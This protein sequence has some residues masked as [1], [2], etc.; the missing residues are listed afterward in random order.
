MKRSDDRILVT[1][2]G[3]LSSDNEEFERIEFRKSRGEEIADEIYIPMLET[4]IKEV[5]QRQVETG[6][7]VIS[8]GELGRRRTYAYY[9]H[10]MDGIVYR[11]CK[12]GEFGATIFN[13]RERR[14]FSKY[15]QKADED[16][17]KDGAPS[18]RDMR[19]VAVDELRAKDT[20]MLEEELDRFRRI[21]TELDLNDRDAFFPVISPG[22]LD[23]FIF[24]E[25]YKSEEEFIFALAE[26][27]RPE[28]EKIVEKGFIVQ[29]DAPDLPDAWA[30][31]VPEITLEDYRKRSMLRVEA[32]NHSLR[33]IPEE[34]VRYHLCWGSWNGP[35]MDDIPFRDVVDLMLKVKAQGY[36]L[37][38]GNVRHE[39]EWKIWRDVK[40]PDGKI[41][42]PGVVSHRTN[43]IEHPEVVSDRLQNFANLVGREN[44]M[45]STDCGMGGGRIP[46]EIGWAKLETMVEGSALASKQLWREPAMA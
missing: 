14:R 4:A 12:P 28:Y 6:V 19:M 21:L 45:A 46:H 11:E 5:I 43:T 1:H 36:S 39:H 20:A 8:D 22:W 18:R 15:Y 37:E 38:A 35:H 13:T 29:V 2:A 40:L 41:L 32:L 26:M 9:R 27:M 24:N 17:Y 44:V 30:T 10:R 23:H 3:R 33:N 42:L 7:D 34:M 16:R 25:H 31:F